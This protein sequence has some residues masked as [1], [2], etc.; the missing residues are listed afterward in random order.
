MT[1]VETATSLAVLAFNC[2]PKGL[3][4]VI[5]NLQLMWT[6]VNDASALKKQEH[7]FSDARK[8]KLGISKWKRKNLKRRRITQDH[9]KA[10]TEGETYTAGGFNL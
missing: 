2:G 10:E 3:K 6:N 1:S 8:Q 4:M 5:K 7:K 9:E